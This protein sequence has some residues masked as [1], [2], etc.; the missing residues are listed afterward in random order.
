MLYFSNMIKAIIIDDEPHA[1]EYLSRIIEKYFSDKIILLSS[2]RNI[3]E[4]IHAIEK[5]NP[6]LVFLDINMQN[7]S[8]FDIL[9]ELPKINFEIIFTTAYSE[10][11]IDAI[12]WSALDY[13]L[14]PINHIELATTLKRLE[15]KLQNKIEF[16]KF[17]LLIENINCDETSN[18]KVA[19]PIENGIKVVKINSILYCQSD[20]NYTKVFLID[21]SH[22]IL[23][24]TLKIIEDLLPSSIFLRV[25]KS[26]LV[27]F[28]YVIY[29][30]RS[31]DAY[32]EL[33][34]HI[35]IPVSTRKKEDVLQKLANN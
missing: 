4:A 29:F 21:G 30:S 22:F 5:F 1:R 27:N 2:S 9:K 16:D 11:A 20:V 13:L 23:S 25:H 15:K 33:S 10:F 28:N 31:L 7:E 24:K 34:N 18:S 26:F 8:G 14:K 35:K 19:F 6:D 17:K 32:L 3:S 12:K